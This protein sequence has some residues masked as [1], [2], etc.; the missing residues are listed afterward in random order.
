[1]ESFTFPLLV[2]KGVG[3]GDGDYFCLPR[4]DGF[5]EFSFQFAQSLD[6]FL[7]HDVLRSEGV[8]CCH[9]TGERWFIG[10]FGSCRSLAGKD[11]VNMAYL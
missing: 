6:P 11:L 2:P 1:M 3:T 10:N 8:F 5:G 7:I 4:P 9:N